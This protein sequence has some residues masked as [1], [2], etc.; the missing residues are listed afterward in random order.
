MELPLSNFAKTINFP[1]CQFM[2]EAKEWPCN[3]SKKSLSF[4]SGDPSQHGMKAFQMPERGR[5]RPMQAMR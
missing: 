5:V 4:M 2:D 3:S 1:L